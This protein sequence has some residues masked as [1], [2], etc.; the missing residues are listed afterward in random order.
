MKWLGG[1][2]Y[3]L[4]E[5]SEVVLMGEVYSSDLSILVFKR[6]FETEEK[7]LTILVDVKHWITLNQFITLNFRA[8]PL[9]N[10]WVS[11]DKKG[12]STAP[13]KNISAKQSTTRLRRN[14]QR[15]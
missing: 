10:M 3:T 1:D 4:Y 15:S 12:E 7:Y 11:S 8:A 6:N 2:G 5:R 9:P 14:S 13:A